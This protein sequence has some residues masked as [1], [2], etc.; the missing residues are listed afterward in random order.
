MNEVG[1][2]TTRS[3]PQSTFCLLATIDISPSRIAIPERN[4]GPKKSQTLQ[5]ITRQEVARRV[6]LFS[7]CMSLHFTMTPAA[8]AKGFII[9]CFLG[10][11]IYNDYALVIDQ[12][13]S[14]SFSEYLRRPILLD[15]RRVADRRSA[16]T[17]PVPLLHFFS[18]L[19]TNQP[20]SHCTLGGDKR[21][22]ESKFSCRHVAGSW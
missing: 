19:H 14:L 10:C 8:C 12:P 7:P 11:W 18:G 9:A 1:K 20:E 2:A 5:M 22:T 4:H 21:L 13:R 6:V 17:L 16:C 15:A 3:D